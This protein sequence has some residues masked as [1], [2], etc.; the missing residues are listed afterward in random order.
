V[1]QRAQQRHAGVPPRD[2]TDELVA[3]LREQLNDMRNERD[4]ARNDAD[5]WKK[6]FEDERA[7][8]AFPVP[9]DVAQAQETDAQPSGPAPD[10]ALAA[11]DQIGGP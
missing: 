8:R 5:T 1:E 11:N 9:G 10:L 4:R 2:R 3:Q 7:Q 6:A